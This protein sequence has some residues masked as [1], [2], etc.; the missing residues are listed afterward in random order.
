MVGAGVPLDTAAERKISAPIW[1]QN[2]I[3]QSYLLA[4]LSWLIEFNE[5]PKPNYS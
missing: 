5:R 2:Q 3:A 1:N 4:A